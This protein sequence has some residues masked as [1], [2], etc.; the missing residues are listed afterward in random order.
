MATQT[1]EFR[2]ATGLTITAKL[3]SAG[4]DIE[5]ASVSATEETNRKG[6]YSVAF[7]D[8]VAGEYQLLA[9]ASAVPV[10]S[11]WVTLTLS[12]A[13]FGV[14]D[15]ADTR[16][17]NTRALDIQSRIPLTL[18]DGNMRSSVQN[19]A[20]IVDSVWDEVL[21]GATHNVP[22]SAGR[23][24]RQLASVIVHSGTAQGAGTGNNQIQLDTG[25]SS[26]NGAYDPSMIFIETG[27]GAGQTRLIL[28]YNGTTKV[29]T[30]DRDWRVNP[31]N[32]SEFVILGDP[33]RESVNEGLAQGA[34]ATTIT[35]N[36]SASSNDDAYNGQLVFIRSGT[37]QDQVALVEDY[38]GST[39][40]ATIKTRSATGQ[41]AV[42][43]DTTSA[44]VMMPNLTWTLEEIGDAVSGGTGTGARTVTITVND[45]TTPLQNAL[46]RLSQGVENYIGKTNASGVIVFSVDDA[47]W[48]V[49]IT[50]SGYRFTPTTLVVDGT[51]TR[52]YSMT[53]RAFTPSEADKVTGYWTVLDANG[54][55]AEGVVVT[56]RAIKAKSGSTGLIH[57]KTARTATTDSEGVAEF[58]NMLPGWSYSVSLDGETIA[59]VAIASDATDEVELGSCI[60]AE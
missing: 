29:A 7:T 16:D 12:T 26:T 35:L 58:A 2:A 20:V 37:G 5:V 46:V 51:E 48:E 57:V 1:V 42:T 34:T 11:W 33:G 8:I 22:S 10:A 49:A 44:Y 18:D 47:T 43:P 56:V 15:K 31:D 14:Y 9:I 55:A 21:T 24:L 6:T 38:V 30:V 54:E 36:T 53:A 19:I 28:Q 13:T 23:R 4:S 3:F 27:T 60:L 39:K 25:A 17:I 50:K 40:V 32:T 59:T 52:T 45:G 41:W